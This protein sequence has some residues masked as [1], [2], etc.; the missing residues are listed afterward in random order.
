MD[1]IKTLPVF[2]L[3]EIRSHG[4]YLLKD[5]KV[6]WMEI[7]T[8]PWRI[9]DHANTGPYTILYGKIKGVTGNFSGGHRSFSG[10]VFP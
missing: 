8:G 1:Y 4:K 10:P 6:F 9:F 5:Q 3:V 2:L 7:S